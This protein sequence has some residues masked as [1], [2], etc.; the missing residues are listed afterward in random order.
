M[1]A[2]ALSGADLRRRGADAHLTSVAWSEPTESEIGRRD[3]TRY[4]PSCL[5]LL[6]SKRY[7]GGAQCEPIPGQPYF[8][9]RA[10]A[11]RYP[12]QCA[13]PLSVPGIA[14]HY[15]GIAAIAHYTL[16]L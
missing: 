2:V 14:S 11:T 5:Y 15:V 1:A 13:A 8:L 7:A 16:Q 6:L 3:P 10:P 9:M 12:A 4:R